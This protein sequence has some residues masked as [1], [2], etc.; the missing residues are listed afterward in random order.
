MLHRKGDILLSFR[1]RVV[2]QLETTQ[3]YIGDVLATEREANAFK[4]HFL[5][6]EKLVAEFA[7][8]KT[9]FPEFNQKEYRNRVYGIIELDEMLYL[10]LRELKSSK[11]FHGHEYDLAGIINALVT[12]QLYNKLN[13]KETT[14]RTE[15][16]KDIVSIKEALSRLEKFI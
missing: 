10:R 14:G 5:D 16:I 13:K 3:L 4:K 6:K 15:I 9:V 1:N 2:Y 11:I 12:Q 8:F 7:E